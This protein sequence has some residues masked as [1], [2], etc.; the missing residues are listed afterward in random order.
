MWNVSRGWERIEPHLLSSKEI[1]SDCKQKFFFVSKKK[2]S[3][4][5]LKIVMSI[6]SAAA[7]LFQRMHF[8]TGAAQF[9][10]SVFTFALKTFWLLGPVQGGPAWISITCLTHQ[11]PN[12]VHHRNKSEIFFWNNIDS[13]RHAAAPALNSS[14]N[15]SSSCLSNKPQ[16][17]SGND[18]LG[19]ISL[20]CFLLYNQVRLG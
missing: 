1:H 20:S 14:S 4:Q 10:I 17:P 18:L 12:R 6:S 19:W 7:D 9:Q 2:K 15:K 11:S 8:V 16:S 3:P 5:H 13:E